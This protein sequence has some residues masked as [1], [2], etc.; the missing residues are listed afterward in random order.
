MVGGERRWEVKDLLGSWKCEG[1][2][3]SS[4]YGEGEEDLKDFT[5]EVKELGYHLGIIFL[6]RVL[7]PPLIAL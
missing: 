5:V 1:V 4:S 2:G 3:S 6:R 7:T